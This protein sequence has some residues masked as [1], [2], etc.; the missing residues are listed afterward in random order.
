MPTP[1]VRL[2][3][4][5]QQ[6]RDAADK[7]RENGFSPDAIVVVTPSEGDMDAAVKLG[8][9]ELDAPV[10]ENRIKEAGRSF[11]AVAPNYGYG[12]TAVAILDDFNPVDTDLRVGVDQPDGRTPFSELLGW[13]TLTR[14][15]TFMSRVWGSELTSK[16]GGSGVRLL[17][18]PTPFSS[19]IGVATLTSPPGD[20]SFGFPLLSDNPTP[21][22][23]M[24]GFSLLSE[25]RTPFSKMLGMKTLIDE[26]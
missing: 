5:E 16:P 25:N 19:A 21:F 15:R 6:A 14:R 24:F 23:K 22:S 2:Y 11:V 20:S 1:Q 3:E 9:N 26:D 17:S 4:T 10:Y 13:P 18:N 12:L 7:L 8:V